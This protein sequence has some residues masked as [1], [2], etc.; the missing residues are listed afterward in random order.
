MTVIFIIIKIDI[1]ARYIEI[2]IEYIDSKVAAS[3]IDTIDI[4]IN[5]AESKEIE[6]V[7]IEYN[8]LD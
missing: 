6:Y 1:I 4:E 2:T 3:T 8:R 5:K 7:N